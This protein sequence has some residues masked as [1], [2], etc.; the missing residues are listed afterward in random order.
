MLTLWRGGGSE[1]NDGIWVSRSELSELPQTGDAWDR[2]AA[3][4]TAD[5][6]TPDL[7]DNESSHDVA[8]LGG[9]IYAA[10]TGDATVTSKVESALV[11]VQSSA[12]N[13]VLEL[14][15]GLQSYV[16]AADLIE[17]NDSAF[18]AQVA[19]WVDAD[20]PGHSGSNS[21]RGTA[22]RSANNWGN[23]ARAS[24]AA[25]ALYLGD[26]SMLD[27]V[28]QGQQEYIGVYTGISPQL[29][30]QDTAWHFN[31]DDKAGVNR[32]DAGILSGVIP[33]DYRRSSLPDPTTVTQLS[34]YSTL[35]T[36]YPWEA[37]QGFVVASVLLD[38]AGHIYVDT[39]T[40]LSR[41]INLLYDAGHPAAGDDR[42]IVY[43]ANK[44]LGLGL[45]EPTSMQD[46]K[47]MGWTDFTHAS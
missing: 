14:A 35:D 16:I 18:R 40:A 32:S 42:W 21:L 24:L 44:V 34:D 8:T 37:M 38:R 3:N 1:A 9:A 26:S 33:E 46:G 27:V 39:G 22:E 15:R 25:S 10:A 17:Y 28:I 4:A 45:A 11:A 7:S 19:S 43:L 47:G 12:L 13:R 29:Q 6:G 36:L 2:L 23:H 41:A 31:S 5:W 30:Y 20:I